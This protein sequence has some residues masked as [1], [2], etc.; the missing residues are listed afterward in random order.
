RHI[1]LEFKTAFTRC[2]G[3]LFNSSVIKV[4]VTVER[5]DRDTLG[6]GTLGGQLAHE[7]CYVALG[8]AGGSLRHL[9]VQRGCGGQ[10]N[11]PKVVDKLYVDLL[12]ATEHSHARTLGRTA[13]DLADTH[14]DP[15]SSL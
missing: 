1:R 7:R 6:G 15:L 13:H 14:L 8:L 10:S 3:Q 5:N 12:V 4:A 11:P 2:V 9:L